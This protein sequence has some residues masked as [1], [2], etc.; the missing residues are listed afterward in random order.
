MKRLCRAVFSLGRTACLAACLTGHLAACGPGLGGTGTGDSEPLLQFFN[1]TATS[2]CGAPFSTSLSCA[3]ADAAPG[4][5]PQPAAQGTAV[6]RFVDQPNAANITVTIEA[7]SIVLDARCLGI[8][9]AGDWGITAAS[10]ARFFGNYARDSAAVRT[11]GSLSVQA[12]SKADQLSLTLRDADGRVLLGPTTLQRVVA[13]PAVVG[14][15]V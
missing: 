6:T 4:S 3:G 12:T 2:V 14:V 13:F 7:N 10:D 1:A 9:F 11:P 15:C 5:M 8:H